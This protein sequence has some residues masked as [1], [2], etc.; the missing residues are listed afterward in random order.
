MD[1][2]RQ[3]DT[4]A[5]RG[6]LADAL[7]ASTSSLDPE[8]RLGF[9]CSL[10]VASLYR[11]LALVNLEDKSPSRGLQQQ[12]VALRYQHLANVWVTHVWEKFARREDGGGPGEGW[13]WYD[14]SYIDDSAWPIGLKEMNVE[15]H[16][17]QNMLADAKADPSSR[18]RSAETP[19]SWRDVSLNIGIASVCAYPSENPLPRYAASNHGAYAARHGYRYRL[20]Q[21]NLAPERP[22]AWGKV[23]LLQRL[24]E[25]EPDVD[26]WLWFD[27]DTFFMNMSVTLDSLL[28]R[29]ASVADGL[30]ADVH[31][32]AAEDAAMLNTGAFLLRRSEWSRSFLRR[33]WGKQDSIW[34]SHPWWENAAMIWDL[35]RF[36]SEKFR[37]GLG[38]DVY[39]KEAPETRLGEGEKGGRSRKQVRILPQFE[40]N[41]YH[42]ATAQLGTQLW[43]A[44]GLLPVTISLPQIALQDAPRHLDGGYYA[45]PAAYGTGYAAMPFGSLGGMDS[46][47]SPKKVLLKDLPAVAADPHPEPKKIPQRPETPPTPPTPQSTPQTKKRNFDFGQDMKSELQTSIRSI[48][49]KWD[50]RYEVSDYLKERTVQ[51]TLSPAVEEADN[52]GSLGHPQLCRRRCIYFAKGHC[53]HG[54]SCGFCHLE[55]T[56][57]PAQLDKK[58]RTIFDKLTE[59]QKLEILLPHLRTK[60]TE[61]QLQHKADSVVEIMERRMHEVRTEGLWFAGF[62]GWGL[63]SHRGIAAARLRPRL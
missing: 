14:R 35:L 55:H 9:T 4:N 23:R 12:H 51:G 5:A 59:G 15:M 3:G 57:Q 33:V 63:G 6:L 48:F 1:F 37:H 29:Y 8:P 16:V 52:P 24:L 45:T 54:S 10:G 13:A 32:L 18:P 27:C 39:P 62:G 19:H 7:L 30:D 38:E 36:N 21:R 61:E 22:P 20:E 44:T 42:P 11:V 40:F 26:W 49:Q 41:S 28:Y 34:I 31:L 47:S 56:R 43:G 2:A 46:P 53:Q 17:V 58:Q 60:A 25:E 50:P